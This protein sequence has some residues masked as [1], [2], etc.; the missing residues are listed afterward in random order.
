MSIPIPPDLA[1]GRVTWT[2]GRGSSRALEAGRGTVRFRPS[3]VAANFSTASALL[4]PVETP[5]LAGVMTPVDLIQNDPEVWNWIVEPL[6]GVQWEPF[7][8]DVDGPVDLAT[9]AQTPGK[10][11][12]R[13]VKGETGPGLTGEV[14]Y[15]DGEVEFGIEDGTWTDPVTMP[16]GP[17]GPSNQLLI[18]TVDTSAAGA[19]AE[20]SISGESPTQYLNLTLPRGEKP[21]ITWQGST[22]VVDGVP[23]QDLRGPKGD[24][25]TE[26]GPTGMSAY[27]YAVQAGFEGTEEEFAE[28]VLPEDVSWQNITGK[29]ETYQPA[30]HQHDWADVTGTPATFPPA[31]HSHAWAD[32]TGKPTT[33]PP[34]THN[35]DTAYAAKPGEWIVL[36]LLNGWEPYVGGGGYYG[37]LRARSTPLGIQINGMVKGTTV[38][39]I[40][41]LPSALGVPASSQ[42]DARG[43][44][45]VST[46]NLSE[47]SGSRPAL[48][49]SAGPQAGFLSI[50]RILPLI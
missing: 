33:F 47:G 50:D 48:K 37:G 46:V 32:I 9:A 13:A 1:E 17:P 36:T 10:G 8:I 44:A 34:A 15:Q 3:A 24:A 21:A 25:S 7:S 31:T 27:E 29:P 19:P 11:P 12:V 4:E 38:G 5:V 2:I 26:P 41:V 16:P 20:A 30:A 43:G 39:E 49:L 40:A 35:H 45:G 42:W 18:G 23:V 28:A 6:V 22:I 14:R